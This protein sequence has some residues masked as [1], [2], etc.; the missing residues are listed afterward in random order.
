MAWAA[1]VQWVA[2]ASPPLPLG[3]V[4]NPIVAERLA[5]DQTDSSLLVLGSSMTAR[6]PMAD[7]VTGAQSVG[8]SGSSTTTAIQLVQ[9]LGRRPR[10][11]VLE[12]NHLARPVDTSET[13]ALPAGVK[14]HPSWRV[15]RVEF[16]PSTLAL[17]AIVRATNR[18]RQVLLSEPRRRATEARAAVDYGRT[19]IDSAESQPALEEARAVIDQWRAAGTVVYLVEMPSHPLIAM[20]AIEHRMVDRVFPAALFPRLSLGAGAFPTTDGRH[21]EADAALR[22]ARAIADALGLAHST[23]PVR[24]Y[25]VPGARGDRRPDP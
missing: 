17:G 1:F 10:V 18:L 11:V 2:P 25:D 21:L 15:R 19:E 14:R 23:I 13:R 12:A 5:F 24:H 22:V 8:L 20:T 7:V 4:Q 16:R 6:L 3:A 9:Q